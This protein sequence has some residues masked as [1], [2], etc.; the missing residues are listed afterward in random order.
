MITTKNKLEKYIPLIDRVTYGAAFIEAAIVL[1]QVY[2]IFSTKSADDISLLT[3]VGFQIL[4]TV[5]IFYGLV[6]RNKVILFYS[7]SYG[8]VQLFV[9]IGGV[10]YGAKW[11]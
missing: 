6:H 5:W 3:W 9:I 11:F 2:R 8:A 7:I 1:P 4:N 10:M